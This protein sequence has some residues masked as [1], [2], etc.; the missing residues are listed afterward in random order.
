M[1]RYI[2]LTI[3]NLFKVIRMEVNPKHMAVHRRRFGFAAATVMLALFLLLFLSGTAYA[4]TYTVKSTANSGSGT[5]R[6]AIGQAN[7]NPGLDT[8][9][10]NISGGDFNGQWWTI[11]LASDLPRIRD[12]VTINGSTQTVNQGDTNPEQIGWSTLH[13]G[14]T[15]GTGLDGVPAT[16]D[17]M[18]FPSFEK[19]EIEINASG[20]EAFVIL[21]GVSNVTIEGVAVFNARN[22]IRVGFGGTVDGGKDNLIRGCIAGARADGSYPGNALRISMFGIQ[23]LRPNYAKVSGCYVGWCGRVGI[24][25]IVA[26]GPTTMDVEYC[27]SFENGWATSAHDGIDINGINSSVRYCLARNNT[28]NDPSNSSSGGGAGIE[29]GSTND[30]SL[31]GQNIVE[32]NTVFGNYHGIVARDGQCNNVIRNNLV[33][34]NHGPG[35]IVSYET[36]PA[37]GNTISKNSIFDNDGLGIDLQYGGA[38]GEGVTRNNGG[39]NATYGNDEMDFPV[40]TLAKIE[41][42]T[43]QLEGYVGSAPGQLVFAGATIEFFLASFDGNAN[44]NPGVST[45]ASPYHGEGKTYLG[46]LVADANGNFNGDLV[47]SS[48]DLRPNDWITATAT[49]TQGNTSEFAENTRVLQ[50]LPV[51]TPVGVVTLLILLSVVLAM[52]TRRRVK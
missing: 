42:N 47:V 29:I 8:I 50:L 5:L 23:V 27:E 21:R 36:M 51:M 4:A 38:N 49:D 28:I 25:G 40:I 7:V 11:T 12:S 44:P 33:F 19:L 43:L 48:T 45:D 6:W 24:D 1:K 15:V 35:I 30:T 13:P 9:D 39:Y 18:P 16:G 10:F 22:G 3:I 2:H 37:N 52:R 14:F 31:N 34:D 17:E 20:Y 41:G 46:C 26:D 32:E